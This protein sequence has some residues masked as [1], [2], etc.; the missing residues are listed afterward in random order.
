MKIGDSLFSI[1]ID[2]FG[3]TDA[4]KMPLS[5]FHDAIYIDYP[6]AVKAD[7]KK[8][9]DATCPR[10]WYIPVVFQCIDC[11]MKFDFSIVEQ[12]FWYERLRF[13]PSITPIRCAS[14]R[15]IE[16]RRKLDEQKPKKK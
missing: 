13:F 7:V 4:K 10:Y 15:K 11:K 2:V 1:D 16:R 8:Q 9:A 12:K 5:M 6:K 14:C 3:D